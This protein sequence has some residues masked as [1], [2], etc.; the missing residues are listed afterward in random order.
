MGQLYGPSAQQIIDEVV[1]GAPALLDT[2]NEIAA[3]IN[4]DT[5]FAVTV[6]NNLALKAP[7]ASPTFTGTVTIPAGASISGYAP[8][9]SPTFTGTPSLTGTT[10]VQQLLE[11]ATVSATA[12][13]NTI[14]YDLLTNGS[15]TYYT[16]DAAGNWT[17]NVRGN[18]TTTLNSLMTTNQSL[19][20]AFLV[21]NGVTA[22]YQTA[23]QVDGASVSPKWQGGTA[24]TSGNAS[25]IDVY[26]ITI[27]KTGNAAFTAL[28]SQ[29][30]FA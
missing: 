6:T 25:S 3:S 28:A 24:P 29:V 20:I 14:N 26:S 9:A 8:T 12:A 27:I 22:R 15:V 5:T 17:L 4:D 21:T 16:S 7:L 10:S 2:L 1:G 19:T 30:K 11:K 13:N 23:F 18:S